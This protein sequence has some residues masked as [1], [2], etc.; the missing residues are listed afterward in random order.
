MVNTKM[1]KQAHRSLLKKLVEHANDYNVKKKLYILY[2]YCML[3]PLII[4]DTIIIATII[5]SAAVEWQHERKNIANAV[6]YNLVTLMENT[7]ITA[8]NIYTNK[9]INEF[10]NE[11]YKSPLDYYN[12]YLKQMED[13]LFKSSIGTSNVSITMYADND[14][15]IS[16]GEFASL[17]TVKD[18]SWYQYFKETK[19]DTLLYIY[20]D[21][22]NVPAV[23]AKRKVSF[24]RKLDLYKRDGCEKVLKMDLNYSD[25]ILNLV[26]MNYDFPVYICADNKILFSNEK[27]SSIGK[28]FE[29]F[30]REIKA[31]QEISFHIYGQ[32]FDIYVLSRINM[33]HQ[34]WKNISFF[35]L[36]PCINILLPLLFVNVLNRSFTERLHELSSV[37]ERSKDESLKE[38]D[39]VQG[40]DEISVLMQNYNR[41][42]RRINELIETVY[43]ETLKKQEMDLARRNAELLA[44]HS[45]INPH[46]LFNALESIRMHSVLKQ[47][48]ETAQMVEKLAKMER[49]YVEW[50]SDSGTIEEELTFVGAYLDLQK[51]RFGDRLSYHI[52]SDETCLSYI[53]P[54]LTLLTFVENAC[55]H[56]FEKKAASGW[57]FVRIYQRESRLYLEVEDTGGGMKDSTVSLLIKRMRNAGIQDLKE[58]DRVGII[59][60]CLRLKLATDHRACFE[61]DSEEGVGTV[62]TISLPLECLECGHDR[63]AKE[64]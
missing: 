7:A 1:K 58:S 38:I 25:I 53:I 23:D 3:L 37:F 22:D 11:H 55:I 34:L 51:Y 33:L 36:L 47:E 27:Y 61:L 46:F 31:S 40:K 44:L 32:T 20:Y 18:S 49:Q 12:S 21:D 28:D 62:V 26:K 43:K 29:I 52:E 2:V 13:S 6:Q 56:G 17:Q 63:V 39:V 5:R 19:K 15:I 64:G 10:M 16:G 8:K 54:K 4:T 57:I 42:A 30:P 14:T 41:M 48:I 59:N 45:Q 24:I 60:A 9:Y 35:F 50:A